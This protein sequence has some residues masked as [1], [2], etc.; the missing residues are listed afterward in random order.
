MCKK[1]HFGLVVALNDTKSKF[2][3]TISFGFILWGQEYTSQIYFIDTF[4]DTLS[5]AEVLINWNFYQTLV[6]MLQQSSIF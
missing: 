2:T 3:V 4:W 6:L 5:R 1:A